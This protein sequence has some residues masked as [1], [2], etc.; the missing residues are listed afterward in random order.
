MARPSTSGP[1][2]GAAIWRSA[3]AAK[4]RRKTRSNESKSGVSGKIEKAGGDKQR[5]WDCESQESVSYLRERR[6]QAPAS[7]SLSSTGKLNKSTW[8]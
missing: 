1:S 5:K 7:L 3:D 6:L 2:P 8:L 4:E